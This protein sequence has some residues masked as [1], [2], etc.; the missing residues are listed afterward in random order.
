MKQ[1]RENHMCVY[2]AGVM[3]FN[4]MIRAALAQ[5]GWQWGKDVTEREEPAVLL[6]GGRAF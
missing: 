4:M 3:V 6:F 5:K 1:E 2:V